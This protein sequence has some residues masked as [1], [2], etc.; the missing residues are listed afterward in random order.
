MS[1]TVRICLVTLFVL[2]SLSGSAQAAPLAGAVGNGTPGSCS[3]AAFDTALTGGGT[4][5]FSCGGS[6]VTITLTNRKTIPTNT[7]VT[8]Q[9]GGLITLSGGGTTALFTVMTSAT[10]SLSDIVL[11]KGANAAGGGTIGS[12]GTVNL[13]NVTIQ[14]SKTNAVNAQGGAIYTDGPLNI[15]NSTFQNNLS[16]SGGAI[17]AMGPTQITNTRFLFN[18]AADSTAG[19][20]GAIFVVPRGNWTSMGESSTAT[21]QSSEARSTWQET[22]AAPPRLTSILRGSPSASALTSPSVTEARSTTKGRTCRSPIPILST[23]R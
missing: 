9:G 16:G 21:R 4:I 3:E 13:T 1:K 11:D 18:Q 6:P 23:T 14:N 2:A 15:T 7:S 5:T 19:G 10:L 8:I 22:S 20:G 17:F 12:S